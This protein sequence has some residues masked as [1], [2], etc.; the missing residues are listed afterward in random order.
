[1][2][3]D[4]D[5]GVGVG[6]VAVLFGRIHYRGR[7]S[8]IETETPA[9]WMIKVRD[10][11]VVCIR[12][13]REPEKALE[14]VGLE[15]QAVSRENVETLRDAYE[16]FRV[17]GRFPAHLATPDFIWDMSNFQDWPGQ[18]VYEGV[19]GAED[20][21]AEWGSAWDSW[22]LAV[23]AMHDAGD[24]VI[25]ILRVR[26]RSK[27]GGVPAEVSMA[28]VVTFRDGKQTRTDNY[29]DPHHALR[30]VGLED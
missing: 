10:G 17:N 25:A 9:G 20:F 19:Q 27:M 5:D 24:K 7:F 12:A 30:A 1:V 23:E 8:G 14:A 21:F 22:E 2:R 15:G 18:Q 29:S 16:W 3:A 6:D 4:V 28:H 11:R 13:F 26:G